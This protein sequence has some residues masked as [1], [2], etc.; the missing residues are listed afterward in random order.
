MYLFLAVLGLC[1]CVDFSL[2]VVCG[3]ILVASLVGSQAL[4]TW[5]A[6]TAARGLSCCSSW[7]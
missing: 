4:D 2:V 7:T 5:E 6:V 1:Y 3:L